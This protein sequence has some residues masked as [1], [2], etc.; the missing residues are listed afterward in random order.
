MFIVWQPFIELRGLLMSVVDYELPMP[1]LPTFP[2]PTKIAEPIDF[3]F[4]HCAAGC[5]QMFV[6]W[7][8]IHALFF[9][10]CA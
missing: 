4:I 9:V 5:A 6:L 1:N 10:S 2:L 8:G 7:P 3:S